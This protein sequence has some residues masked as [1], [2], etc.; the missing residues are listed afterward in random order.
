VADGADPEAVETLVQ[1]ETTTDEKETITDGTNEATKQ[2]DDPLDST[3][4]LEALTLVPLPVLMQTILITEEVISDTTNHLIS[5]VVTEAVIEVDLV[6]IEEVEMAMILAV[7]EMLIFLP[8]KIVLVLRKIFTE[9]L[10]K[11]L[12]DLLMKFELGDNRMKL[13]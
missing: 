4:A 13:N 8:S 7:C 9:K 10:K 2:I 5:E 12:A 1:A 11:L 3:K 6:E